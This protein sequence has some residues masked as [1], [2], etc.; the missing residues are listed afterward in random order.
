MCISFPFSTLFH[1]FVGPINLHA[2]NFSPLFVVLSMW[3][4]HNLALTLGPLGHIGSVISRR[5]FKMRGWNEAF[6]CLALREINTRCRHW[7][8]ND[9]PGWWACYF[10][11]KDSGKALGAVGDFAN[12]SLL[13]LQR[14]VCPLLTRQLTTTACS[15]ILV[16]K[17]SLSTNLAKKALDLR[18]QK[19]WPNLQE[20]SL[21]KVWAMCVFT[22][23]HIFNVDC[24]G[25]KNKCC[26]KPWDILSLSVLFSLAQQLEPPFQN[27]HSRIF[28]EELDF[29]V[30]LRYH[31]L[32]KYQI[33]IIWI[34]FY[35]NPNKVIDYSNNF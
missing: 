18:N 22:L 7:C 4:C 3:V 33:F 24:F 25:W 13:P 20:F 31:T 35:S 30:N 9:Y 14:V 6:C 16:P 28:R 8:S 15:H 12:L 23:R 19:I 5:D 10:D 27:L 21:L 34:T 1:Y 17:F 26:S 11:C 29:G 32:F 2:G